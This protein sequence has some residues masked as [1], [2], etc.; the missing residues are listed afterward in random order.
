MTALERA[1]R[2]QPAELERLAARD[3][4]ASPRD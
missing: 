2:S 1:I 4:A 3:L